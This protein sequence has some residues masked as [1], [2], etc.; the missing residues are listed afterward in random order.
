M[1]HVSRR[2]T[3]RILTAALI[4]APALA[5]CGA[6]GGEQGGSGGSGETW[7]HGIVTAKADGG[8]IL[9]AQKKGYYKDNGVHVEI[10]QFNGSV[11]LV[12]AVVSGAVDSVEVSPD[13]AYDAVAKGADLKI[14]GSTLPSLNYYLYAKKSIETVADLKGKTIG[15]SS[16]GS[17]PDVFARAVLIKKGLDPKSVE[18]TSSGSSPERFKALVA[19]RIDAMASSP[20]YVK[21]AKPG[22]DI[23]VIAKAQ[24]VVPEYPRFVI[25]ANG[26]SLQEKPDAAARFLA[27]EMQGLSYAV[28]HRSAEMKVAAN[29]MGVSKDDPALAYDYDVI[30]KTGAASPAAEIPMAKL[31]WLQQFRL[32]QGLQKRKVD[33]DALTDGSYRKKALDRV[34]GKIPEVPAS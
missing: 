10:K 2:R 14:I 20:E 13:P 11:D 16:P 17:L 28:H 1:S 19:G 22:D 15:T 18:V 7:T 3:F 25:V 30:K 4:A 9:M 34:A 33:L 5:A 6:G 23:H 32:S 26:K 29:A 8:F 21:A 27:G 12:R 31:R 24:Q